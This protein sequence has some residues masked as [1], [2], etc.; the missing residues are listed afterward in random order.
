M[1]SLQSHQWHGS[2]CS[3]RERSACKN[4][5]SI[6]LDTFTSSL[7]VKQ[8]YILFY[9]KNKLYYVY[10]SSGNEGRC[11]DFEKP[12]RSFSMDRAN[13]L[14]KFED[15]QVWHGN[16]YFFKGVPKSDAKGWKIIWKH[17]HTIL[18][19][20]IAKNENPGFSYG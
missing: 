12:L 7:W 1:V 13:F 18:N 8:I 10:C 5:A 15:M 17:F 4:F 11:I 14:A 6:I 20:K 2:R 3:R 9:R 16:H 19:T